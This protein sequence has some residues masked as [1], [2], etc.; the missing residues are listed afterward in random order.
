MEEDTK[1]EKLNPVQEEKDEVMTSQDGEEWSDVEGGEMA[2]ETPR[3]P[4][5][6]KTP[7]QSESEQE[8]ETEIMEQE[9]KGLSQREE[10]KDATEEEREEGEEGLEAKGTRAVL[11]V[12]KEE[13]EKHERT[14]CPFRSWC[15]YCV[16]GRSHKRPHVQQAKEDRRTGIP[17]VSMD[18]FFMSQKDEDAKEYPMIV[19]VDEST[20]E[21]SSPG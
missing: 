3:Q 20:G 2:P 15:K 12:T 14:H 5:S 1:G 7:V 21:K 6:D 18:Y 13:R 17:R 9:H 19:A 10:P 16:Q 8:P 4:E 11:N